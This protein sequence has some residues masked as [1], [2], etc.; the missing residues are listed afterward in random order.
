MT[1]FGWNTAISTQENADGGFCIFRHMCGKV[2]SENAFPPE[3]RRNKTAQEALNDYQSYYD[4]H[5]N[6]FHLGVSGNPSTKFYNS[7]RIVG[8]EVKQD[9]RLLYLYG[10]YE[11]GVFPTY[12]YEWDYPG[13]LSV[14]PVDSAF[15]GEQPL[16][17]KILFSS[18]MDPGKIQVEIAEKDGS[19]SIPVSGYF[20]GGHIFDNDVWKGVCDFS[21]WSG[22]SNAVVRVDAEDDELKSI[23]LS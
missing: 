22:G 5:P 14:C 21:E 17:V 15:I 7:P 16:Q 23:R 13:D 9:F 20:T 2:V 18:L 19:F 6:R 3:Q 8:M 4:W 1:A 10:F 11:G 12:P